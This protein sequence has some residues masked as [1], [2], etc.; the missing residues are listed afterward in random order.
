MT[1]EAPTEEITETPDSVTKSSK[2]INKTAIFLG[3]IALIGATI[4][5]G[6]H[7]FTAQKLESY[8]SH[9]LN[10]PDST[11][12]RNGHISLIKKPLGGSTLEYCAEVN[13]KN[14]FNGYIGF[15]RVMTNGTSIFFEND[16]PVEMADMAV[17]VAIERTK[18]SA[19]LSQAE[20]ESLG[21][22]TINKLAIRKVFEKEWQKRCE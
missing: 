19:T 22:Y 4:W 16:G 7:Y 13:T 3:A 18:E 21:N 10:D 17:E 12:F 14:R 2:G 9:S 20:R 15:Q 6:L 11:L 1:A 5:L 8:I